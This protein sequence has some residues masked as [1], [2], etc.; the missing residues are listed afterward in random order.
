MDCRVWD[1]LGHGV[2]SLVRGKKSQETLFNYL[3]QQT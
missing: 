3:I 1:G 2:A